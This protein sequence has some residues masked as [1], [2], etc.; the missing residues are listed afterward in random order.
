MSYQKFKRNR[1]PYEDKTVSMRMVWTSVRLLIFGVVVLFFFSSLGMLY[2][3]WQNANEGSRQLLDQGSSEL[4][5]AERIALQ[6]YL[7][8]QSQRLEEAA[9]SSISPV[10]FEIEGGTNANQVAIN[11]SAQGV[12]DPENEVLFLNYLRYYGLD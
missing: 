4:S 7:V 5:A 12:I 2:I 3:K 11:L 1:N 8:M 10:D 9:G 6:G